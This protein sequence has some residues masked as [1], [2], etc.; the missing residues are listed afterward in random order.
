MVS[1]ALEIGV[2]RKTIAHGKETLS[3]G[4]LNSYNSKTK[5]LNKN[6]TSV[7]SVDIV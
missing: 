2:V 3:I 7:L 5:T 1:I 6:L 4:K